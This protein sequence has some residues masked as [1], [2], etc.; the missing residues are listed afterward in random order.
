MD[1]S[2]LDILTFI[3]SAFFAGALNA[4]AGGGTFFAF[5]ALLFTGA[6]PIAANATCT[7]ALWPASLASVYAFRQH[8]GTHIRT[9]GWMMALSVVGGWLGARILLAIDNATFSYLVPWLML[10]A[11]LLFAYGK[12]IAQLGKSG[13][14]HPWVSVTIATLL[15]SITAIYGGFFGAGIGI[16]TLAVLYVLGL[17]DI[18]EMNARKTVIAASIN[19]AAFFTFVFSDVVMWNVAGIM[20]GSAIAGGYLGA[21]FSLYFPAHH[22]RRFVLMVATMTTGYF[23]IDHYVLS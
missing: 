10:I 12:R 19:S 20:V 21:R 4:V 14:N 15:L 8:L 22:V 5:P 9:L 6:A 16:L 18:H 3:A 7:I 1:Y 17:D 23:F 13:H 11:T 2:T